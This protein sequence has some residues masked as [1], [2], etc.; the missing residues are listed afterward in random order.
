MTTLVV[1][2]GHNG[3]VCACYLARA[4]IDVL[5]LEQSAKP[6][7]GSRTEET[8]PR[9][10][11]RHA[12]GRAQHHQHD[13]D[14]ARA[15]A[16]RGRAFEYREMD[17]FATAVFADGRRVRFHRSVERTVASIARIDRAEARAYAA[18]MDDATA[19]VDL[20]TLA[21]QAGGGSARADRTRPAAAAAGRRLVRGGGALRLTSELLGSY[22]AA[23]AKAGSGRI[24]RA[25]RSARSRRTPARAPSSP[26]ARCSGS[27]RRPITATGSGMPPAERRG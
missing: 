12:L 14:P 3:L 21:L 15:R 9:L 26:A 24:S 27:G 18:F 8:D 10:P 6:G 17:P 7:G 20:L 16:A 2:A 25:D 5:V 1:G 11:L 23:A 4:G 13:V 19:L 22:G